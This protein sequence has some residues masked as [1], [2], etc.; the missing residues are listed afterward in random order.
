VVEEIGFTPLRPIEPPGASGRPGAAPKAGET[1]FK[2][3]LEETL[4][5]VDQLQH[6]AQA[7]IRGSFDP[8]DPKALHEVM[9]AVEEA[10]IAFQFVMQVRNRLVDA[11]NEVM[12]MQV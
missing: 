5:Q 11:Y 3:V 6:Q 10:N 4:Q 7:A 9:I 1:S 12:R 2:E 8:S